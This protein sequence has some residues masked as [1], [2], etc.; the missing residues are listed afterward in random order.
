MSPISS[1]AKATPVKA[2][3]R[4]HSEV[5]TATIL[6]QAASRNQGPVPPPRS[7]GPAWL[8]EERRREGVRVFRI[9]KCAALDLRRLTVVAGVVLDQ[10]LGERSQLRGLVVAAGRQPDRADESARDPRN[11]HGWPP[12]V[13]SPN[14]PGV[15]VV[16]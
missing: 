3:S 16:R 9:G 5:T 4:I 14:A 1:G 8:P 7:A 13:P 15:G 6:Q 11:G 10:V 2:A 12:H